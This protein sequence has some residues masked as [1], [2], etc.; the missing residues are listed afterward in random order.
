[1]ILFW[2]LFNFVMWSE[3]NFLAP[4][5]R[6]QRWIYGSEVR[7]YRKRSGFVYQSYHLF[8]LKIRWSL[9]M[10]MIIVHA[11]VLVKNDVDPLWFVL[12]PLFLFGVWRN[13]N[14]LVSR[15]QLRLYSYFWI[16]QVLLVLE[17]LHLY[18]LIYS[19]NRVWKGIWTKIKVHSINEV[20][21]LSFVHTLVSCFFVLDWIV[22]NCFFIWIKTLLCWLGAAAIVFLS[23][24]S[25]PV[26][27]HSLLCINCF[28]I[29]V[30]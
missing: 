24:C 20:F 17:H 27:R 18:S 1:M 7:I 25:Q 2:R 22:L 11:S 8:D 21:F 30:I 19:K 4:V 15:G 3:S 28:I 10:A 13:F 16:M 26:L 29:L 5:F 9:C 23:S 6:D 12:S 14:S